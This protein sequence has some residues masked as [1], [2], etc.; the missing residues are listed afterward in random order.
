[1][2][3]K[4]HL[5]NTFFENDLT[6]SKLNLKQAIAAHANFYQLQFIP[7]LYANDDDKVLVSHLSDE[8]QFHQTELIDALKQGN[9]SE[10]DYWGYSFQVEKLITT[11]QLNSFKNQLNLVEKLSS[12]AFTYPFSKQFLPHSWIITDSG[13][14]K[15]LINTLPYPIVLKAANGFAGRG[16]IFINQAL[17][18]TPQ[19]F[20]QIESVLKNHGKLIVEPWLNRVHDFSSQWLFDETITCLGSTILINDKK[21][22]Y[23][24]N[25]VCQDDPLLLKSF[26]M[27]E[28][29]YSCIKPLIDAIHH[30]GFCGHLGIDAF[31]YEQDGK[32]KMQPI[33]EINPRKTMG[34]VAL[35]VAEK[36]RIQSPLLLRLHNKGACCF[37]LLP[38]KL[39]VDGKLLSFKKNLSVTSD[40]GE[41]ENASHENSRWKAIK[42][43][44]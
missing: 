19:L 25:I 44:H 22:R 33:V 13:Q 3:K 24:G 30:L 21:G 16:H 4:L 18:F 34:Y 6:P 43:D 9:F 27:I 28:E 15:G 32:L 29:H 38:K 14:L 42:W 12:K 23:Q 20:D 11:Y 10:L 37:P 36:R 5:A 17:E 1:M 2:K 26:P 40:L 8:P 7:H 35:K 39:K 31:T 41:V